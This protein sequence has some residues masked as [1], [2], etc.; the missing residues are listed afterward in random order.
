MIPINCIAP[1]NSENIGQT[2]I[3]M[4]INLIM[5]YVNNKFADQHVH[6][7][8]LTSI[9]IVRCLDSIIYIYLLNQ[10]FQD[11]S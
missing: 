9:F 4:I 10:K 2:F 3:Y 6:P 5:T 8:S 1:P 7:H 11:S